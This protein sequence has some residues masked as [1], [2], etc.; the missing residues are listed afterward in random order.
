MKFNSQYISLIVFACFLIISIFV[1]VIPTEAFGSIHLNTD[2]DPFSTEDNLKV[3]CY[4]SL[5]PSEVV[6]VLCCEDKI[7]YIKIDVN[8]NE[9]EKEIGAGD[10]DW[11]D[12]Q[13]PVSGITKYDVGT[14]K[15]YAVHP[16][17]DGT[18]LLENYRTSYVNYIPFVDATK[19]ILAREQDGI[20]V[21]YTTHYSDDVL[22]IS[23]VKIEH[24]YLSLDPI[25]EVTIGDNVTVIGETNR[26][27]GAEFNIIIEGHGIKES[28][29]SEVSDRKILASFD[30]KTWKEG[31]DYIVTAEDS[32]KMASQEIKFNVVEKIP[33][34]NVTL[35]LSKAEANVSDIVLFKLNLTNVGI[36]LKVN[37]KVSIMLDDTEVKSIYI[38]LNPFE[39]DTVEYSFN[40]TKEMVGMHT[41]GAFGQNIT[42]TVN[43]P[44]VEETPTS[45]PQLVSLPKEAPTEDPKQPGFEAILAVTGLVTVAFILRKKK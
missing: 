31:F 23:I 13:G 12:D 7:G 26:Q 29:L 40:I 1:V 3:E 35:D 36:K 21:F 44:V 27:N 39:S 32:S 18:T 37:E 42:F 41:I 17:A 11:Y 5:D 9:F 4:T 34:M 14:H 43:E 15:I 28:M 24:P 25:S 2:Y 20:M 10:W 16:M 45:T 19:Y 22:D 33:K 30:T 6:L 8:E 38:T